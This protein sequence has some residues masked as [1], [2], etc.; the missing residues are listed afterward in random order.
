MFSQEEE[1][2]RRSRSAEQFDS[3]TVADF[4]P[5]DLDLQRRPM[6]KTK[7][8]EAPPGPLPPM[9]PA[10]IRP[11]RPKMSKFDSLKPIS[12]F[13]ETLF[14]QHGVDASNVELI[15]FDIT[16]RF[17]TAGYGWDKV[18]QYHSKVGETYCVGFLF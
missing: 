11:K 12:N 3:K 14:V 9:P 7:K 5:E 10:V 4:Y 2:R 17:V 1:E 8:R 13:L 18:L 6:G 16:A 15:V